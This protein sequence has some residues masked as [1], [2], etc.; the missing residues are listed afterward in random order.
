MKKEIF[1]T[2]D[3]A[4]IC[5]VSTRVVTKWF[6][7]ELIEGFRLP[8]SRHRRFPYQKVKEFL[9]KHSMP[10]ERLEKMAEGELV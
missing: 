2:S 1:T 6:D 10:T 8:G 7:D 5:S 9:V 3:V 4:M